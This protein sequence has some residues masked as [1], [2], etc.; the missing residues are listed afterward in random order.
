M[1]FLLKRAPC[2][3]ILPSLGRNETTITVHTM[4]T[5]YLYK[6][7]TVLVSY[8]PSKSIFLDPRSIHFT[9]RYILYYSVQYVPG[10]LIPTLNYHTVLTVGLEY[11]YACSVF[12]GSGDFGM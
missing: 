8:G 9:G 5:C 3:A 12:P 10:D 2:G 1:Q 11:D 4:F 6:Y 7:H